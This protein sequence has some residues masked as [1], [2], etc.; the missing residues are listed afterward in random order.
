M[1]MKRVAGVVLFLSAA[2]ALIFLGLG[3]ARN[4]AADDG[5]TGD[6]D[7][8]TDQPQEQILEATVGLVVEQQEKEMMG[9]TQTRQKLE[10][11]IS[12]GPRRREVIVVDHWVQSFAGQVPYQVGDKV[13][14]NESQDMEGHPA[15]YIVGYARSGTLLWM[16]LLFVGIVVVVGRLRGASSLLGMALS[17]VVIFVVILPRMATGQN[18]VLVAV[19]GT[20]LAM[21]FTYYLAHGLNRK[22]TVALGGSLMGLALTGVLGMVFVQTTHLSGY[23][24]EEAGFL[25]SMRPGEID[26]KGL[27]L[28]GMVIS[29]LG[30]LDDITVA[31]AAIVEQLK[32]ANPKLDWRQLYGRAMRVGQDHIASMV[33]TLVLVYAGAALPLLLLL[34]DR[35]LP[36]DYVISHEVV[37]EQ[38]VRVLVTS[39]GL[40]AAV[41]VTTIIA[42]LV[43]DLLPQKEKRLAQQ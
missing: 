33:N 25:Q 42:S 26:I 35:S 36:L 15:Y 5:N 22:T 21:P 24:S 18:P 6:G 28:A 9:Y 27:L 38:A 39:I 2:V 11:I 37:A 19:L 43:M 3:I 30:V 10:L 16:A 17:F 12:K 20:A 7:Q 13:Y 1:S 29:V 4:V 34:S 40:V 14:V 23:A 32:A 41:P 31:Q 8:A